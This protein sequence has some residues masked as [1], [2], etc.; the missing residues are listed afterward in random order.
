VVGIGFD[1]PPLQ[2]PFLLPNGNTGLLRSWYGPAPHARPNLKHDLERRGQQQPHVRR[3]LATSD[4]WFKANNS[5]LTQHLGGLYTALK[6][7]AEGDKVDGVAFGGKDFQ[8]I[9]GW[10]Y[11]QYS[12]GSGTNLNGASMDTTKTA[13]AVDDGTQLEIGQTVL[14]GTLQM[15]LTGISGSYL[16][17]TRAMNGSTA[18]AHAETQISISSAGRPRLNG[19]RWCKRPGFGPGQ[20]S[21]SHAS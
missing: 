17:V 6:A 20:P 1:Q 11:G 9:G 10:G 13:L 2:P 12:E 21:L 4:Y 3:N 8:I 16:T 7:R 15:R 5:A 14:I 19:P 18:A